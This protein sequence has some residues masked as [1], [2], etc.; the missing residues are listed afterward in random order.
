MNFREFV[1]LPRVSYAGPQLLAIYHNYS[2]AA[3]Y[4]I[5]RVVIR[6]WS[7]LSLCSYLVVYLAQTEIVEN[8]VHCDLCITKSS[9]IDWSSFRGTFTVSTSMSVDKYLHVT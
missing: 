1:E 6:W 4:V 9:Y 5:R 3:S 2:D 7:L 8:Y